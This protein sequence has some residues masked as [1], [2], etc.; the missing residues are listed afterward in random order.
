MKYIRITLVLVL[1]IALSG[2][3]GTFVSRGIKDPIGAYPYQAVVVDSVV[4]VD[5]FA[6]WEIIPGI[7]MVIGTILDAGL[8]TVLLVPDLIAWPCG[9]EK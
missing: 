1:C 4:V 8:D 7:L 6:N 9:L 3:L 5:S 2:C